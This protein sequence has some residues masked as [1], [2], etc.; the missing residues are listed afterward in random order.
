MSGSAEMAQEALFSG[1]GKGVAELRESPVPYRREDFTNGRFYTEVTKKDIPDKKR[2]WRPSV[3]TIVQQAV[4]K[5]VGW[6]KWLGNSPSYDSAMAFGD[7]AAQVGDCVHSFLDCLVRGQTIPT[8]AEWYDDRR[9][10]NVQL[11]YRHIKRL[12]GFELFWREHHPQPLASEILMVG[13]EFAGTA[14]LICVINGELWLIDYKT[15]KPYEKDHE[16]QIT[17]Y[18]MLWDFTFPEEPIERIGCLYL[19][20]AYRTV[21]GAFNLKE[22]E[23]RP[24]EWKNTVEQWIYLEGK[25]GY[26][27]EPRFPEEFPAEICLY[28]EEA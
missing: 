23:Y 12:I 15:G 14:D 19:G 6:N 4:P 22:Y 26:Q 11:D 1:D 13:E 16:L 3:T 9:E 21:R 5:G 17:A 20:D 18:K 10:Q 27:P 8:N 2:V 25:N 24:E 7:E 28:E